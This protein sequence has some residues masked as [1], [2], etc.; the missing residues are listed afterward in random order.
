MVLLYLRGASG[1][2]DMRECG[3]AC[4]KEYAKY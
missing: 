4:L 3:W 1:G 2:A